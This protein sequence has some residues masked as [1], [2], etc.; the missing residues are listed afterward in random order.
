MKFWTKTRTKKLEVKAISVTD[1]CEYC[2]SPQ[3]GYINVNL[4]RYVNIRNGHE[5]ANC[6]IPEKPI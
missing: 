3:G 4:D 5:C 1:K 6:G 2:G